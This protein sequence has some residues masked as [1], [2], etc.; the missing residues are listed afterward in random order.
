MMEKIQIAYSEDL[1]MEIIQLLLFIQIMQRF[2]K[3][4]KINTEI[5]SMFQI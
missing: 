3:Q 5:Q 2:I 4:L 1:I